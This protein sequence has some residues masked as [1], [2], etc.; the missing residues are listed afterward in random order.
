[1]VATF[2][3]DSTYN[4]YVDCVNKNQAGISLGRI[5]VGDMERRTY[6]L[7]VREIR[8]LETLAKKTGL[9]SSELVRRAVDEYTER[10]LK[11]I[12]KH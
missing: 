3:R 1:M 4:T 8:R 10:E 9:N 2:D 7:T 11:K 5:A 6:W 12:Q